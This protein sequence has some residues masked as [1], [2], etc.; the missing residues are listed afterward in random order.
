MRNWFHIRILNFLSGLFWLCSNVWRFLDSKIWSHSLCSS[1][2]VVAKGRHRT[3][4]AA[5]NVMSQGVHER[6]H[7][8]K[9]CDKL[10]G[11]GWKLLAN[12]RKGWLN[13]CQIRSRIVSDS[14]KLCCLMGSAFPTL[15]LVTLSLPIIFTLESFHYI[16]QLPALCIGIPILEVTHWLPL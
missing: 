11:E 2:K 4:R 16:L 6:F 13:G 5:K 10:V 14:T 7:Q 8:E 12:R 3:A 9:V 15:P 1:S